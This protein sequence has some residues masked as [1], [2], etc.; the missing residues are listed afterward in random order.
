MN[1]ERVNGCFETERHTA[2]AAL[3]TKQ[4]SK[5]TYFT[6]RFLVD[7]ALIPYAYHA[8]AY[9]R[10]MDDCLDQQIVKR[11]ERLAFVERQQ[12][13]VESC[14][15]GHRLDQM[16]GEEKMLVDLI[17]S[18]QQPNSGLQAYIRNMMA[19]MT[20]DAHVSTRLT[21]ARILEEC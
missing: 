18:D 16:T 14:Y 2:S 6:I 10:W 4:A 19:V 1:L 17:G 20:F 13:L 15:G 11:E 3:M 12:A 8:Y 21:A 9:F 7:R 5:Q